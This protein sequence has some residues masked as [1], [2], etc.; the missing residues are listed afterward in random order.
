M[1][2]SH[3]TAIIDE[4]CEIGNDVK[5]W[6][7]CHLMEGCM[8]GAGSSLGQNVFIGR[9]VKLGRNVKIQ[10]NVSVY[11]GVE[12][13]DD[14]FIG[15]SVVFTNVINPRSAVD[16]KNEYKRTVIGHGVTIGANATLLCGISVGDHA[17]IGAGAVVT[18]TVAAFALMTGNPAKQ[19]GWMSEQGYKLE[20][21]E[22]GSGIC[23]GSK[24]QY[25]LQ[26]NTVSKLT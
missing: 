17:F 9:N 22:K 10:N 7:F 26:N 3:P 23:P 1:Y 18:K 6:H 11:E 5:I 12:C 24:Q 21:D 15:P 14:V 16:R 19:T 25:R 20:F 2:F 4:G 13:G 8:I